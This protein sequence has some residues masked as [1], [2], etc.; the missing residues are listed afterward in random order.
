MFDI[1][2]TINAFRRGTLDVDCK[3]MVLA[4]RKEGGE[5]FQ[6]QGYIRQS[7]DGTLVFKIY[8]TQHNAK[9][10]GHLP[11]FKSGEVF[12]DDAFYDLDASGHEG[13]RWTATGILP[14]PHWNASDM[15]VLVNA[16]MQSVTAHLDMPQPR[17][18]LRMHFFEEYEV[19]LDRMRKCHLIV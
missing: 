5:H 12:S 16:Q 3:R 7:T 2:E 10:F 18:Y 15:S 6:G 4:Q 17:H 1:D 19:P 8:V 14:A 13:T 11:G 9:P